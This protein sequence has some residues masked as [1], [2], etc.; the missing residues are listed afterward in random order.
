MS[1][2]Q[3]IVSGLFFL[4]ASQS[5]LVA[6][7]QDATA[8]PTQIPSPTPVSSYQLPYPGMLP[9][10]PL[11]F[12]KVIRDDIISFFISKPL[13]KADFALTQSDKNVEASYLMVTTE[14]GKDDLAFKTFSQAQDYFETAITQAA[15]AR[16]QGYSITE[17][18]KKL[19]ASHKNHQLMLKAV[20]TQTRQEKSQVFNQEL[21]REE[22]FTKMIKALR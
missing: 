3:F 10:N 16:R 5:T 22:S 4:L 19:D 6:Y 9:D 11:Y 14:Q 12:L 1:S 2:K 15:D 13:E 21:S 7:A 20:G 8:F 17:M 18:Y